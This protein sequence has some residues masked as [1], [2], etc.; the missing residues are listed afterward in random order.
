MTLS[1]ETALRLTMRVRS[2][3]A[4]D[5][6]VEHVVGCWPRMLR[7][8]NENQGMQTRNEFDVCGCTISNAVEASNRKANGFVYG[9]NG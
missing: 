7:K 3:F 8:E 9:L 5:M 1:V 6:H 2:V 4:M